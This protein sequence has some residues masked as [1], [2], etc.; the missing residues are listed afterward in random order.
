MKKIQLWLSSLLDL[1]LLHMR[2][3]LLLALGV[4]LYHTV[5]ITGL[6]LRGKGKGHQE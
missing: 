3:G 5:L 6:C 4:A 1:L 2:L